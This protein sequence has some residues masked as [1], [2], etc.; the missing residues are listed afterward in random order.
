MMV[1]S[2]DKSKRM[3]GRKGGEGVGG[4]GTPEAPSP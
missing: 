3:T 2:V 4:A 1:R